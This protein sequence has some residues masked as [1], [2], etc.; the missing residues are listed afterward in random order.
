MYAQLAENTAT[1][2]H[3]PGVQARAVLNSVFVDV[4][5][6]DDRTVKIAFTPSGQPGEV[7]MDLTL[8]DARKAHLDT[9]TGTFLAGGHIPG[10]AHKALYEA[11]EVWYPP[12]S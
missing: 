1:F 2:I 10:S 11:I 8:L 6:D 9:V 5:P 12:V 3:N 4:T 7:R